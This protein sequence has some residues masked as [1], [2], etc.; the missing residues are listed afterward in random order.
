MVISFS[1]LRS[2]QIELTTAQSQS[3]E[4]VDHLIEETWKRMQTEQK[5][6]GAS[7]LL[8]Q[9]TSNANV[10][11]QNEAKI[12]E[13]Q[14]RLTYFEE[15]LGKLQNRKARLMQGDD[16]SR[17]PGGLPPQVSSLELPQLSYSHLQYR[18]LLKNMILHLVV[19]LVYQNKGCLAAVLV[20]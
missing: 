13:T 3:Q 11:R 12:R 17:I 10:L 19:T 18:S 6:M 2:C 16:P 9:A 14:L 7:Q 4:D 8:R 20:C 5:I 1:S 15:T